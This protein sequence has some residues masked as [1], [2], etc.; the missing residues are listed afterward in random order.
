MVHY[1]LVFLLNTFDPPIIYFD[2]SHETLNFF[3]YFLLKYRGF[4]GGSVVK[5][6]PGMQERQERWVWTLGREGPLEEGMATHS[7]ILAWRIAWT[8][9][10]G[11]L[12][13]T[14]LQRV[15]HDWSDW[16]TTHALTETCFNVVLLSAV[17]CCEPVMCIH[18]SPPSWA[19]SPPPIP[20]H[21][22]IT[23]HHTELPVLRSSFPLAIYL[24]QFAEQQWRRRHREQTCG[25]NGRRGGHELRQ[26]HW[27]LHFKKWLIN[28][29]APLLCDAS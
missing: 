15:G 9:K 23:E 27:H 11:G 26:W 2:M 14:G 10:P 6:V 21:W 19:S 24:N 25:H 13:S 3:C 16:L 4:P 22:V 17:Q 29:P 28:C 8:E 18:I 1:F 7:S 20:A 5:N 12:Q